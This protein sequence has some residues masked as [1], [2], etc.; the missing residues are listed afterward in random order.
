VDEEGPSLREIAGTLTTPARSGLVLTKERIAA[1]AARLS[2][3]VG[4][5]DR[6]QMLVNVFRAAAEYERI[7][8][9]LDAL[10]L[11]ADRWESRY[12]AWTRE[13]PASG[14]I[15]QE[16]RERLR[17]TRVLLANMQAAVRR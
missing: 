13:Y 15:W 5:T 6:S 7:P 14:T 4:F 8:A 9:L 12:V 3:P 1:I 17:N 2:L 10:D 11:E 16:W